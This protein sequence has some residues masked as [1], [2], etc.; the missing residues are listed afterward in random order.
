MLEQLLKH[1]MTHRRLILA[2]AT[3]IGKSGLA[4]QLASYASLRIGQPQDS[5]TDVKIPDDDNNKAL[6]K[7]RVTSRLSSII[8]AYQ[9]AS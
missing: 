9:S 6:V 1:L 3:G 4:R 2:G 7:V 8:I 5:V